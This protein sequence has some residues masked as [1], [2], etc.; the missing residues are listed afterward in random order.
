MKYINMRLKLKKAKRYI[1]DI[2]IITRK[3]L[4]IFTIIVTRA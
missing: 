3:Y 4:F 2:Q 1:L